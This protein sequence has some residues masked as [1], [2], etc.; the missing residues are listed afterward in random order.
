[1]PVT[2]T[3]A[4]ENGVRL[5]SASLH[6]RLFSYQGT[7]EHGGHGGETGVYR[8]EREERES[9]IRAATDGEIDRQAARPAR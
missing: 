7:E 8:E 9:G 5:L 3:P 2:G 4:N 6:L 1:M